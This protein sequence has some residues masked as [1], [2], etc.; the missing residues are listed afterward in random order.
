MKNVPF[1]SLFT[2]TC[3]VY[4]LQVYYK[5]M[6]D[7]NPGEEMLLYVRDAVYPEK[8]LGPLQKV[9]GMNNHINSLTLFHMNGIF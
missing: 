5:A 6:R 2:L 8:D 9:P 4:D 7:I 1:F 3:I